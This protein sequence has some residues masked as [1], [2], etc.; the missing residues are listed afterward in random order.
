MLDLARKQDDSAI[1]RND[2]A[3]RLYDIFSAEDSA[4]ASLDPL[5]ATTRHRREHGEGFTRP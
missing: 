2:I 1:L 4:L 3:A 5:D